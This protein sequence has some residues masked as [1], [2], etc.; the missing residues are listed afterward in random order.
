MIAER[1]RAYA[2]VEPEP[3]PMIPVIPLNQ[4]DPRWANVPM[5]EGKT[6]G[7]WGCLLACY[8]ALANYWRLC[9]ENPDAHL[10]RMQNAGA[11]TGPY[12][13]AGALKTTFPSRVN[14]LGF[15]SRNPNIRANIIAHLNKGNPVP[16][17]VDFNPLTT[18]QWEQHWVLLVGYTAD[19]FMMVDPWHGD[20]APVGLRYNIPG[21][22]NNI[23][24]ALYYELIATP[25]PI[26]PVTVKHTI[27]L[28]PQ[29]TTRDELAALTA[30][31]HPSR[32]AFTYSADVAHAVMWHGSEGS[33]VV[34]VEGHRW[35]GDIYAWMSAR[36]IFYTMMDFP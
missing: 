10:T 1:V 27:Y 16:A 20:V 32:S 5:G 28:L 36:G 26:P 34:I 24:E 2:P 23:L 4:R 19:D 21:P 8:N 11:M 13:N 3:P 9:N 33:K 31:L 25:D 22:D 14:Y 18:G 15:E 12:M 7:N 6:I 29:D 35:S 17:R 30:Q